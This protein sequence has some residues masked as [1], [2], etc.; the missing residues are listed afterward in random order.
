VLPGVVWHEHHPVEKHQELLAR[1]DA[2]GKQPTRART[3]TSLK[4]TNS[5][6]RGVN[7]WVFAGVRESGETGKDAREGENA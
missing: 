4:Q 3:E 1:A 2:S 6:R 7:T 5:A